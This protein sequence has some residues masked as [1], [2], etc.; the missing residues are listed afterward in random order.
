VKVCCNYCILFVCFRYIQWTEQNFP[1]GGSSG[2]LKELLEN[3]V[4]QFNNDDR[5]QSDP[6]FLDVWLR[7]VRLLM[8]FHFIAFILLS[9]SIALLFSSYKYVLLYCV[10]L[11]RTV[12]RLQQFETLWSYFCISIPTTALPSCLI[13][14]QNGPLSMK[15]LA[16]CKKLTKFSIKDWKI[17]LSRWT[18][19]KSDTSKWSLNSKLLSKMSSKTYSGPVLYFIEV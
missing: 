11:N 13:S 7:L 17:M 10:K 15:N 5:Y 6:R 18:Y 1:S 8:P 19:C 12:F 9:I 3:A 2:H 16:T 14:M 4:Q